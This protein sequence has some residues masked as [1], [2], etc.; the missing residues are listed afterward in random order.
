MADV[1]PQHPLTEGR[2]ARQ[3][4]QR[5]EKME[6]YA[7]KPGVVQTPTLAGA[8]VNFGAPYEVAGYWLDP[9]GYVWLRG[10][11]KGGAVPLTVFTLAAGYRP[12]AD[13]IFNG[14]EGTGGSCRI[15]V[16]AGGG[17]LV[18][19]GNNAFI[20]LSGIRFRI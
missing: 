4:E 2:F 16:Q 20:S 12:P 15:D 3:T 5:V 19:N 13:L 6:R 8:W 14:I 17:V 1:L 7:I 9:L 11:I 18:Q 10:L